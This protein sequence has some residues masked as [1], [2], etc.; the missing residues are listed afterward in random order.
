MKYVDTH[1]QRELM[2]K[3]IVV[4]L[5]QRSQARPITNDPNPRHTPTLEQLAKGHLSIDKILPKADA[6]ATRV[7]RRTRTRIVQLI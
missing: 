6:P 7:E 2:K 5:H 1:F 3:E 4:S